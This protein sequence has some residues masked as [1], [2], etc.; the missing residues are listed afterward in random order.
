MPYAKAMVPGLRLDDRWGV[1]GPKTDI[2]LKRFI[3]LLV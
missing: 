3:E 1:Y 2:G